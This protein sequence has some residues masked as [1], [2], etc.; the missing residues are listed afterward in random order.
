MK[1]KSF[2]KKI[3]VIGVGNMA[4]AILGGVLSSELSI[5]QVFLFDRNSKQYESLASN[6]LFEKAQSISEA[7]GASDIVLLSVKPQN[8][9][10]VLTEIKTATDFDKKLYISI[11]AGISSQSVSDRLNGAKVVRVLP[12][13]PMLIGQGVSVI[14]QNPSVE[15]DDFEFICSLFRSAGSILLIDEKDMN[16]IIGVTSSSPAYVF[17][18][19]SAMYQG[20][21]AQ[22]LSSEGL[23]DA[24]CDVVIG[25][26]MTLKNSPDSPEEWISRVASKG[27]TTERALATL[28]DYHFS[29]AISEAMKACTARADE[30]GKLS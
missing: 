26:A 30:L 28:N 10:E 3:A 24:I 29:E 1:N 27:G 18:F 7:V 23:L 22:G 2:S 16:P 14:C 20:A 15:E 11:G 17:Q 5:S 6:A 21:L 9:D 12:N 25:S 19:I 8:Y 13:V 4:K